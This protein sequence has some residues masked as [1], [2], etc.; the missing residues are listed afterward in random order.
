M[1]IVN[2]PGTAAE[3]GAYGAGSAGR[4]TRRS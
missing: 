4:R 2:K 3:D 1:I